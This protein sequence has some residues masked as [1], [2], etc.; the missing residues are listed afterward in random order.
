MNKLQL[1]NNKIIP[2]EKLADWVTSHNNKRIVFTNGCFDILHLGHI[3]YL[4]KAADLGDVL[5]IGVNT[6]T[7]TQKLK[8]LNRPI[9]N[10]LQRTTLLAALFFVDAVILFDE[11]TPITLITAITPNILVKGADYKVENIIGANHVI[12]NGGSVETIAFL[13]GY[14]TTSIENKIINN[15]KA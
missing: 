13:D 9:N 6:D 7:S 4:S 5:I 8:G 11:E 3:D 15:S 10:E 1:I 14:S 2:Q 12:D